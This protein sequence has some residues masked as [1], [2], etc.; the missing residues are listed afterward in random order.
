MPAPLKVLPRHVAIDG[1]QDSVTWAYEQPRQGRDDTL[2]LSGFLY[3][4]REK[5]GYQRPSCDLDTGCFS[6]RASSPC[7]PGTW[8][9]KWK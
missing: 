9:T 4:G 5:S 3:K 1:M 8:R 6:A 2:A 7:R